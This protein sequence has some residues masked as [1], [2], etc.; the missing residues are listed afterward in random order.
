MKLQKES[1]QSTDQRVYYESQLNYSAPNQLTSVVSSVAVVI[2]VNFPF[3]CHYKV[4]AHAEEYVVRGN[5]HVN[6]QKHKVLSVPKTNTVI[7]PRTMMI[8]V[9]HT[10]ITSRAVMATLWFE[11]VTHQAV[12]SSL[13]LWIAQVKALFK[14]Q[15]KSF[16]PKYWYLARV[17]GHGLEKRPHK[18][19]EKH[20]KECQ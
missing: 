2:G 9:Q 14:L 20:M 8:H 6:E 18:Q 1:H 13:V 11:H 4:I 17:C 3:D 15:A 7:N 5:E 10:S 12:P 16:Y 19:Y